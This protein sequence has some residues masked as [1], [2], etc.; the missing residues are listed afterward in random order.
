ME[1]FFFLSLYE[2]A[3]GVMINTNETTL[4][5]NEMTIYFYQM[6]GRRARDNLTLSQGNI[7]SCVCGCNKT[8]AGF[9]PAVSAD[10][11]QCVFSFFFFIAP[12]R[13]RITGISKP[14]VWDCATRFP[15]RFFSLLCRPNGQVSNNEQPS[16][17]L[18]SKLTARL[19]QGDFQDDAH[20]KYSATR[21]LF[22]PINYCPSGRINTGDKMHVS[23]A[24]QT[25]LLFDGLTSLEQIRHCAQ[26]RSKGAPTMWMKSLL[27]P[28]LEQLYSKWQQNQL[29]SLH[30]N[31]PIKTNSRFNKR[32]FFL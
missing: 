14:D 2:W 20:S 9:L 28:S 23:D 22:S 8:S 5:W 6:C 13:S 10:C 31:V 16:S 30:P 25:D 1:G 24:L 26:H 19:A 11:T 7:S 32:I 18:I 27:G 12:L 29:N 3:R 4:G 15:P 21:A 17:P